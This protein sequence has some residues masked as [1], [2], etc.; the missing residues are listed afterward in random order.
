[1]NVRDSPSTWRYGEDCWDK[2]YFPDDNTSGSTNG[3][4]YIPYSIECSGLFK[5]SSESCDT[6]GAKDDIGLACCSMNEYDCC[7]PE[8]WQTVIIV[9]S[10]IFIFFLMSFLVYRSCIRSHHRR[11]LLEEPLLVEAEHPNNTN[12]VANEYPTARAQAIHNDPATPGVKIK[13]ESFDESLNAHVDNYNQKEENDI[14][15]T[16]SVPAETYFAT[17]N[18]P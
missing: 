11:N 18:N 14:V 6:S 15:S 4:V 17:P 9:I 10:S 13:F 3:T 16:T 8:T 2:C 1:M 7:Q 12:S 5:P